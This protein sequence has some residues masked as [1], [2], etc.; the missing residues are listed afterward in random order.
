MQFTENWERFLSETRL[1]SNWE[2]SRNFFIRLEKISPH[3]FLKTSLI[4]DLNILHPD[5][6]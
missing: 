4:S 5:L 6:S 2:K 1:V 3:G